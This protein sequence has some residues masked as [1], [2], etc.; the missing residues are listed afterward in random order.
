MP[1]DIFVGNLPHSA[2][3]SQIEEHFNPAGRVHSIRIMTDRKGRSR[4]FGFIQ[5]DNPDE[6]VMKFNDKEFQGRKL[7]VSRAIPEMSY[8]PPFQ[9][10]RRG[11][12]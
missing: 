2:T 11:G 5:V 7:R 6:A 12:R 8:R 3:E 10:F 9:R 1:G 4:C